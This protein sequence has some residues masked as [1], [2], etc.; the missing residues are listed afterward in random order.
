MIYLLYVVVALV[1]PIIL[2]DYPRHPSGRAVSASPLSAG[3]WRTSSLGYPRLDSGRWRTV[4]PWYSRLVLEPFIR[5]RHVFF[6]SLDSRS[7]CWQTGALFCR[8]S[9]PATC[10][11]RGE[12]APRLQHHDDERGKIIR[13]IAAVRQK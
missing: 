7:N 4:G 12:V 10:S 6:G 1:I 3:S 2:V 5:Y 8:Q 13:T 11:P 9:T